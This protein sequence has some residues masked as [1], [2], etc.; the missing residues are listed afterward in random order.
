[1]YIRDAMTA[2]NILKWYA[3]ALLIFSGCFSYKQLQFSHSEV[4]TN[5]TLR[6]LLQHRAV[7]VNIGTQSYQADSVSFNN[8]QVFLYNMHQVEA[9]GQ[10]K[11]FEQQSKKEKKAGKNIPH[12]Y[13]TDPSESASINPKLDLSPNF[14]SLSINQLE[15]VSVV[16][17]DTRKTVMDSIGLVVLVALAAVFLAIFMVY[18]IAYAIGA[19][20]S[21]ASSQSSDGSDS[22]QSG[23]NSNSNSGDSGSG[24]SGGSSGG[25]TGG[26]GGGGTGGG[27]GGS[28]SD[29][30]SGSR[31]VFP[32]KLFKLFHLGR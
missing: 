9:V 3:V 21:Q 17:V 10:L 11:P 15:H 28:G 29:S 16:K 14:N 1:V 25:G 32:N 13:F 18:L 26:G 8:E 24:A 23:S 6:N 19:A 27:G 7:M 12:L 4:Q 5:D 20:S 30:G 2:S 31:T 22:G